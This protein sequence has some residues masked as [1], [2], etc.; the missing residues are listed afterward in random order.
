MA[1]A[2]DGAAFLRLDEAFHRGL[3]EGIGRGFAW[4]VLESI[5]AQMDR[6]R[7]LSVGGATPLGELVRQHRAIAEGIAAGDPDG[8][9]RAMHAHL[10]EILS[11]LPRI[12]Q[13]YPDY[14][15]GTPAAEGDRALR[16]MA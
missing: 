2:E 6:V 4:T 13:A 10:R 1:E 7:F 8:T 5:K 9:E 12:A 11:S 16:L 3:A 15:Q 14:F